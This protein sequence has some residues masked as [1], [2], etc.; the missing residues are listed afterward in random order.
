MRGTRSSLA[1]ITRHA[2][3]PAIGELCI[4]INH[5]L[6]EKWRGYRMLRAVFSRGRC[7]VA[8]IEGA[9]KMN[10]KDMLI[11]KLKE[12]GADGLYNW[13]MECGCGVDDFEPCEACVLDECVAAKFNS[14]D[15]LYYPMEQK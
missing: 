4:S 14:K 2:H 11:Q 9:G 6:P 7:D 13:A 10:A 1:E 8:E 5:S 12:I 15:M 3:G